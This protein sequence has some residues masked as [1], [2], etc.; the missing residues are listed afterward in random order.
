M[1]RGIRV[2]EKRYTV[3]ITFIW[4]VRSCREKKKQVGYYGVDMLQ[5]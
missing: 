1:G 4:D 2:V 5:L 3:G